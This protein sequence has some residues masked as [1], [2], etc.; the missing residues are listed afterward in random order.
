MVALWAPIG[1]LIRD[2]ININTIKTMKIAGNGVERL[3][4][5]DVMRRKRQ[6]AP[7]V[8]RRLYHYSEKNDL[9]NVNT[10]CISYIQ[11]REIVKNVKISV[12]MAHDIAREQPEK[13]VWFINT[14]AGKEMIDE[15]VEREIKRVMS[16]APPVD[17]ADGEENESRVEESEFGISAEE[18]YAEFTLP[19]LFMLNVATGS[20]T[21]E[22]LVRD[23]ADRGRPLPGKKEKKD[24]T[25]VAAAGSGKELLIIEERPDVVIII[26]SF[27]FASINSY[28][29]QKI[30]LD[31]IQMQERMDCSLVVFSHQMRQ[32]VIAGIPGR[33]PVG[34][35]AAKAEI[36][37]TLE[38][39]F[40]HLIRK[41]TPRNQ[42]ERGNVHE[43][44]TKNANEPAEKKKKVKIEPDYLFSE[45]KVNPWLDK[46][47]RSGRYLASFAIDWQLSQYYE[48]HGDEIFVKGQ[49][50]SS[51]SIKRG[52]YVQP[53]P[54][55]KWNPEP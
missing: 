6:D 16:I 25:E 36:V 11:S 41:R 3:T 14:Y 8:R 35:L 5:A 26:N 20:W 4:F 15:M 9:I 19:N 18:E 50:P 2:Y 53:Q 28:A 42:R 12:Q 7:R 17:S 29:K 47:E 37:V 21:S 1:T 32:D 40:E 51:I 55:R 30:V 27:E 38:D 34:L 39:P 33:G 49:E 10:N 54:V 48:A 24:K 52:T 46:T 22:A 23:I 45:F 13:D 44:Q 43:A 31:L